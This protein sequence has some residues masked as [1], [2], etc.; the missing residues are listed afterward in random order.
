N[1]YQQGSD[2]GLSNTI[3]SQMRNFL[4]GPNYYSWIWN[5]NG[6]TTASQAT[7]LNS[8][9]KQVNSQ[10]G[11][12]V[13]QVASLQTLTSLDGVVPVGCYEFGPSTDG[14]NLDVSGA[15]D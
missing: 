9:V 6:S 13:Q 3:F 5:G 8:S 12:I 1:T 10:W 7:I 11:G 4:F 14:S 2:S 15:N